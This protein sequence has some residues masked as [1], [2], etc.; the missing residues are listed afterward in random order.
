MAVPPALSRA[1]GRKICIF[2]LVY[3]L[4]AHL[5]FNGTKCLVEIR[6]NQV[7]FWKGSKFF[8]TFLRIWQRKRNT[9]GSAIFLE[10]LQKG[11][12]FKKFPHFFKKMVH[13]SIQVMQTYSEICI[14]VGYYTTAQNCMLSEIRWSLHMMFR[15]SR[16]TS[17]MTY[18][19]SLW[20]QQDKRHVL[21]IV[22]WNLRLITWVTS[23]FGVPIFQHGALI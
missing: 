12:I 22:T 15:R 4:Q 11:I 16:K 5:S 2:H 18:S 23:C 7:E 20:W 6:L 10:I 19:G 8:G 14:F 1:I 21:R 9:R 13:S 3:L 17:N